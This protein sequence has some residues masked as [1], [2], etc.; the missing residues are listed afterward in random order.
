[1]SNL[2][3]HA[4]RELEIIAPR[5]SLD[6][7][8]I[9]IVENILELVRVFAKQNHSG[10]TAAY[11]RQILAKL[12]DFQPLSPLTGEDDEWNKT[13]DPKL[14]QNT[15]CGR[16]FRDRETGEAFDIEGKV[17]QNQYGERFFSRGDSRVLIEFPYTPKTEVVEVME[18]SIG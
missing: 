4:W 10:S 5:D 18:E 9:L 2:I 13:L 11:V 15:R 16:V 7:D 14:D 12:L 1:M 17:L 6:P 8:E 3:D